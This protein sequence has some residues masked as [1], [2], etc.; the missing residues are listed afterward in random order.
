MDINAKP[1]E[2]QE[3]QSLVSDLQ[4]T[5][6]DSFDVDPPLQQPLSI[7][8]YLKRQSEY[9]Q[10]VSNQPLYAEEVSGNLVDQAASEQALAKSQFSQLANKPPKERARIGGQWGA[11]TGLSTNG[12][13]GSL[14]GAGVGA[15]A[16]RALG[17][18]QS[19][20]HEDNIRKD[21]MLGTLSTMG[22][23]NSEGFIDF[24]DSGRSPL[25]T[26]DPSMRLQNLNS[27]GE[28][29]DRSLYEIDVSNPFATRAT[30]VARP[31][32]LYLA[33]GILG[34]R[35]RKNPR[36]EQAAKNSVALLTNSLTEGANSIDTVFGRSRK[37]VEKYGL[38]EDKLRKYFSANKDMYS[39]EEAE[40]IRA[41]LD[42]IFG[43]SK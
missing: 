8:N 25:L 13:I 12:T 4:G 27:F 7:S 41:G 14:I 18:I 17:V 36:D 26:N 10:G 38:D 21:K 16:A 37:L 9:L 32:G 2:M 29:K 15:M 40:S 42:T 35:D 20:E 5:S 3:V 30:T 1:A 33:Q 22:V 11:R 39:S 24:E 28:G 31:L 43:G 34:Y 23:V 19:G 6:M